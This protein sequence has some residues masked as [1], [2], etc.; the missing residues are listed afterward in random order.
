MA[1]RLSCWQLSSADEFQHLP[2]VAGLSA[3]LPV[4]GEPLSSAAASDDGA[5]TGVAPA[6]MPCLIAGHFLLSR[7]GARKPLWQVLDFALWIRSVLSS[8]YYGGLVPCMPRD[9]LC[10]EVHLPE[11]VRFDE[12]FLLRPLLAGLAAQR[13]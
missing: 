9:R 2:G 1:G 4:P 11:I 8:L 6:A 12:P 3:L 13:P 7:S 10:Y 5:K